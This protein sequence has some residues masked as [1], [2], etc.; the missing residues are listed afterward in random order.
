MAYSRG[1]PSL[2]YLELLGLYK[3]WH[4]GG[5][6]HF[7]GGWGGKAHKYV[8]NLARQT[9]SK[10]LLDYGCGRGLHFIN[11]KMGEKDSHL[12]AEI[13]CEITGY[14]PAYCPFSALPQGKFD[15]VVAID[16]MEHIPEDD[17][18]WVLEEIFGFARKFAFFLVTTVL[19]RKSFKDGRNVH[20]TVRPEA[21]WRA[22]IKRAKRVSGS[23]VKWEASFRDRVKGQD[24]G[25]SGNACQIAQ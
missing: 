9:N 22:Q 15:G 7:R 6:K 10:T 20:V 24:K 23:R 14:D 4:Q 13:G 16:V 3:E 18:P 25:E 12:L 1:S 8:R 11:P 17:V 5:D 19:A 21:W 2:F